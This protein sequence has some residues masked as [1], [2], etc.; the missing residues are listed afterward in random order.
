VPIPERFLSA[1]GGDP[2]NCV[3][4][5]GAGLSKSGLRIGGGGIPDWDEL[6]RLMVDHL[7]KSDR[8]DQGEIQ[9]LRSL[10][11]EDPPRYLEVAESFWAAHSHDRDGYEAFLRRHLMPPDLVPSALHK[12]ILRAGFRGIATYNFDLVFE[13]QGEPIS[14]VVYPDLMTQVG[15][16]QR[17]GFFAKLHGSI[18]GPAVNLVL[19][20][21]S[22]EELRRH[23]QY[24]DLLAT[25]FLAHK[26]LC[27]GFSLRDPDFLGV[28]SDLKERWG[29]NF[30]PLFALMRNAT[31]EQRK[32]WLTK[33]LDI[34][35]YQDHSYV[36]TF[37]SEISG[38]RP[39]LPKAL[40]SDSAQP[41]THALAATF[42]SVRDVKMHQRLGTGVAVAAKLVG[43]VTGKPRTH[44][45]I[46]FFDLEDGTGQIQAMAN[47][48]DFSGESWTEILR[49]RR[50]SRLSIVGNL[51]TSH[52][53][54][55]TVRLTDPPV[56]HPEPTLGDAAGTGGSPLKM[57]RQILL[58]RLR[59][60]GSEFFSSKGYVEIEPRFV[61]LTWPDAE[62]APLRVVYEG[63]GSPAYLAP[64]PT[65]QL[66]T[67]VISGGHPQVFCVSRCFTSSYVDEVAGTE[68][69]I[70]SA[71]TL[72][73]D[74]R[75]VAAIAQESV[76][77]MLSDVSTLPADL[78]F[79]QQQWPETLGE[80]P[81]EASMQ[82]AS[83][84][85]YLFEKWRTQEPLAHSRSVQ[86]FRILWPALRGDDPNI[87]VADGASQILGSVKHGALTLHL[88]RMI[89]VLEDED[90]RRLGHLAFP[91]EHAR[92]DVRS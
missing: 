89:R 11:D 44:G 56:I 88:D 41:P 23:P 33:G 63:F 72:D 67:A 38:L 6:M 60:R 45:G 32:E 29:A 62:P 37:F 24:S 74:L 39:D 18:S 42:T 58:A 31:V 20:R 82:L 26:V 79:L 51:E 76:R 78:T 43:L 92:P 65:S 87:V 85:V 10:L 54:A 53:G 86:L 61:S 83:P 52:S 22:Y 8:Y 28:L 73:A 46:V 40:S 12:L 70:L 81:P 7:E 13:G 2:G 80:W 36:Q 69:L 59:R 91:A 49:I 64:S 48:A 14:P 1:I 15:H 75:Q 47:R 84:A 71:Q 90:V 21:S 50:S 3:L 55:T 27:V 57:R 16:F 25:L 4:L 5:V 30:P 34:L 19:T 77:A 17:K 9:A 68:S 35:P 66:L